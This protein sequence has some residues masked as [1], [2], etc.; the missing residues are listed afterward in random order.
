MTSKLKIVLLA[1]FLFLIGNKIHAQYLW[2]E[3]ESE[4]DAIFYTRSQKGTFSISENNPN[5]SG[6]NTNATCSKFVRDASEDKGFA[7]FELPQPLLIDTEY[8]ISLK[9]YIDI[10]TATLEP[11]NRIRVYLKNTTT[12]D[13]EQKTLRFTIGQE[14]QEFSFVF[15]PGDLAATGF[16][17]GGYNQMYIG[18]GNGQLASTTLTYY[19]DQV[20][21]PIKEQSTTDILKASWGGRLYVR[22]GEDLD[23]YVAPVANG[24]KAYDYVAGAQ[25]IVANYPTMGHVITNATNNA[26]AQLWTLRTNP[27]VDAIMGT[28]NAI[29]D[30]EFVPSLANEQI[31]IDIINIFKNA[32]KKVILYLNAQSPANRATTDGS[33]A[34]NNYV[35]TYFAGNPHA[36]W[37][38]YC[39]GYIKRYTELGVDG[40]WIDSFGSYNVNESLGIDDVPSTFDEKN[41]FVQM[42]R[43]TAPYATITT[44]YAKD[45]FTDSE[46]DYLKVDTDEIKE[47]G[48]EVDGNEDDYKIIKMTAM[49]PWSDFTAGH[50]TPLATGAPPNSWA[51]EEFTVTA[52]EESSLSSYEDTK[53]TVKHLFLPIRATWSSERSDLRF[54]E[55]QA[56]RFV[57]RITDAGGSVTF[58]NTTDTDGTTAEDEVPILTFI[59]QQ[60]A[61]DAD[62]TVYERPNGAYLVGEDPVLSKQLYKIENSIT[63]I[64]PNPVKNYFKLSKEFRTVSIYSITGEKLLEFSGNQSTYSVS[65]LS[66][67]V[68]IIKAYDAEGNRELTRFLKK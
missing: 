21:G 29:V 6:I 68:Y 42:I 57:K 44:N 3:N 49:D 14:W 26:N 40:Y 43:K 25:E 33:I 9:A 45:Y 11:I 46:G 17:N 23:L 41:E 53:Q 64:Q 2:Y 65:N 67:G 39:E 8:T 4:T 5:D 51:Y 13:L 27:N 48:T 59:D 10:T 12:G 1:S 15:S 35:D 16:E 66:S 7:Y 61:I 38:N 54:D 58:S 28:S 31:I 50:I 30:E 63:S 24:G 47:D 34:W 36:A 55:E 22:G 19:V 62:P 52:I 60:L 56:Y 32:G 20:F 37:M 18:F